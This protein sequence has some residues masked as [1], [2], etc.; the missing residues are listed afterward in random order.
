METR[1]ATMS[2]YC[3]FHLDAVLTGVSFFIAYQIK[4]RLPFGY[5]GLSEVHNYPVIL[6][7]VLICSG[8]SYNLFSLYQPGQHLNLSASFI[9]LVKAVTA[10]IV[11]LLVTLYLWH[12][13]DIS[14]LLLAIFAVVTLVMLFS[15]RIIRTLMHDSGLVQG[16]HQREVLIIGSYERARDLI[17]YLR[18]A[19]HY[20][21]NIIGCL[22]V[23][24]SR[25]GE[26]VADEVRIIGSIENYSDHLLN[27]AVDDVI[28]TMPLRQMKNP[29]QLIFNTEQLGINVRIMPDWQL[30][31]MRY[32]PE[33]A[34]VHVEQ[35]FGLPTLSLTST[36]RRIFALTFKEIFDRCSALLGLI[37]LAP[38]FFL[39]ALIIKVTS[40]GP[41]FF[42][43]KRSGLNGRTFDMYKFRSMVVDAEQR[44]AALEALNEED[45]PAF[46]MTND[47]RITRIGHLLRKTSLDELPQLINVFKGEMSLVGPRPPLPSEVEH[48]DMWQRRRLSMR[49]GIT[50]IWQVKGRNNVSFSQWMQMDLEYIDKWSLWLDFKLLLL[51]LPAVIFGSGR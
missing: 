44:R 35:C 20:R 31:Q 6:L 30:H 33:V 27:M 50:C 36:P 19:P 42:C 49:P 32:N 2:R 48:Y 34:S 41:V 18:S 7:L 43:Q 11:M 40:P 21:C 46:K 8:V 15:V 3:Y 51:T 13:A 10:V 25:I 38:L 14:R 16:R 37:L 26:E 9:Q 28:I 17:S 45:G 47:P 1:A 29:S 5:S 23:D 39:I 22:E 12:M 4:L 24:G